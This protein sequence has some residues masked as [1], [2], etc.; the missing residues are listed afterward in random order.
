[1]A[2]YHLPTFMYAPSPRITR[3]EHGKHGEYGQWS[4]LVSGLSLGLSLKGIPCFACLLWISTLTVFSIPVFND[5]LA[6]VSSLFAS[7]FT[8]GV[9]G[10]MWLFLNWGQWTKSSSKIFLM[11][12]N[13]ALVLFGSTVCFLG[14]YAS[15]YAIHTHQ[16]QG[17]SWSCD[18]PSSN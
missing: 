18:S 14:L 10:L 9:S 15:G 16:G 8:Y 2:I 7:W 1:M 6:L 13:V 12:I 5:L 17:G 4:P 3:R 11:V